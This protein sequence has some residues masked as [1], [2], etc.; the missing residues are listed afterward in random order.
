MA[1]TEE[2]NYAKGEA[3][4]WINGKRQALSKSP[5]YHAEALSVFVKEEA[6]KK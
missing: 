6:I 1:G 5:G 3:T 4:L 2:N